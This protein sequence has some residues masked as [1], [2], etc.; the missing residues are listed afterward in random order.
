MCCLLLLFYSLVEAHG[1]THTHTDTTPRLT[2]IRNPG[3]ALQ[4][5][6]NI[7]RTDNHRGKNTL[8]PAHIHTA[9][10]EKGAA[11][12][13]RCHKK[14]RQV[15]APSMSPTHQPIRSTFVG[16]LDPPPFSGLLFKGPLDCPSRPSLISCCGCGVELHL[17]VPTIDPRSDNTVCRASE[18]QSAAARWCKV[19]GDTVGNGMAA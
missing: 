17:R 12:V 15:L 2:C 14:L 19:C 4:N 5:N 7:S 6:R 1:N 10:H 18:R 3:H 16:V 13:G 8:T 11:G 9:S